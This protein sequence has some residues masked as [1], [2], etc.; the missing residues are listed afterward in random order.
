MLN[1]INYILPVVVLPLVLQPLGRAQE[2]PSLP[3]NEP[4]KL[5]GIVNLPEQPKASGMPSLQNRVSCNAL[6]SR[7]NNTLRGEMSAWSVTVADPKASSQRR[8]R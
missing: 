5:P 6:Q 7:L 3:P 4:P 2:F 1:P 8:F